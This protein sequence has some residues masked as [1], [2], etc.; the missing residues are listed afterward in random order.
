MAA[1]SGGQ[2]TL[3]L[4]YD[5]ERLAYHLPLTYS[6]GGY[7]HY[8]VAVGVEAGGLGV[9]DNEIFA[10]VGLYKLLKVRGVALRHQEVG[11]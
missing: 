8:V 2:L 1:H 7:L 11:G 10:V 6:D 5:V 9:E 4:E 3:G